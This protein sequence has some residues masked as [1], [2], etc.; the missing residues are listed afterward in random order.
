MDI[1]IAMIEKKLG[2]KRTVLNQ[3][4][5]KGFVEPSIKGKGSKSF[6]TKDD[7]YKL[8]VFQSLL[9]L[10]VDPKEAAIVTPKVLAIGRQ[11]G[12]AIIVPETNG[13]KGVYPVPV[14]LNNPVLIRRCDAMIVV[15][16]FDIRQ[17]VDSLL[18]AD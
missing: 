2:I 14:T 15:N 6:Y 3:W 8:K 18:A 4:N 17:G 9:N 12:Y 7:A 13:T 1:T 10:N 5:E 16:I 11:N